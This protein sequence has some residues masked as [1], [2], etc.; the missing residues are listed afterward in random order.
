VV[1][2]G[3]KLDGYVSQVAMV[4]SLKLGISVLTNQESTG[5]YWSV[6]YALLDHF[7]QNK[8]FDWMGGFKRSQDSSEARMARELK[9]NLS[10]ERE[11]GAKPSIALERF[12]GTYHDT[13]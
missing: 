13:L 5:A 1:G 11:A 9:K 6:I 7:M 12:T 8:P 4:P 2:H 10:V 3:G